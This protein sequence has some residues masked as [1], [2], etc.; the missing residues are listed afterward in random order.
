[1]GLLSFVCALLSLVAWDGQL[2]CFFSV[3]VQINGKKKLE[4]Q[5]KTGLLLSSGNTMKTLYLIA[6]TTYLVN[7]IINFY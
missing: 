3:C 7:M 2:A 1:M 5:G 6:F 4:N